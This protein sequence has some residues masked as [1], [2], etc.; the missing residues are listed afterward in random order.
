VGKG[1]DKSATRAF[2]SGT[3]PPINAGWGIDDKKIKN[4]VFKL[5]NGGGGYANN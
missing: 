3:G 5:L 2:V 1:N 4:S